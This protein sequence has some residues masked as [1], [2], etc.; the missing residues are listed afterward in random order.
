M[1][2][3]H[4]FRIGGDNLFTCILVY[5]RRSLKRQREGYI[6][7]FLKVLQL[8]HLCLAVSEGLEADVE[9][10][11]GARPGPGA[12]RLQPTPPRPPPPAANQE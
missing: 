11:G 3:R 9:Q 4:D 8:P 10:L 5:Q 12:A 1:D 6:G 7:H 2:N